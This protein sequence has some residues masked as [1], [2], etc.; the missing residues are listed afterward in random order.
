MVRLV[1]ATAPVDRALSARWAACAGDVILRYGPTVSHQ[2]NAFALQREP[3][4][5]F[6]R[7]LFDRLLPR[8]MQRRSSF[9][10]NLAP[11]ETTTDFNYRNLVLIVLDSLAQFTDEYVPRLVTKNVEFRGYFLLL[12]PAPAHTEPDIRRT[13]QE[14][15]NLR[16]HNVLIGLS[17]GSRIDLY[18]YRPYGADGCCECIRPRVVDRCVNG[19]LQQQWQQQQQGPRKGSTQP[20]YVRFGRNFYGCPLRISSFVRVPFMQFTDHSPS[21]VGGRPQLSGIEGNL[22]ELL[23]VK[24]NFTPIIV[25]PPDGQVWG[26]IYANGTADG[27]M[28][29]LLDGTAHLTLG[30][31]LPYPELLSRTTQSR[32][33][34]FS[35]IVLAVREGLAPQT[36]FGR[37]LQPF[38]WPIWLLVG[39]ELLLAAVWC[40]WG[41]LQRRHAGVRL[42]LDVWRALIGDSLPVLPRRSLTRFL[43]VLWILHSTLLREC[44]KGSLVGYLTAATPLDDISS[45]RVMLAGGYR[46]AMTEWLYHRIFEGPSSSSTPELPGDTLVLFEASEG[47]RL[48]E[49]ILASGERIAVAYTREEII[50]FNER[51]RSV[52][53]FRTADEKLLTF[54]FSAYFKRS[55]PLV[56]GFNWYIRRILATGFMSRWTAENLDTRFLV[57]TLAAASGQAEVLQLTHLSSSYLL[58]TVGLALACFT[59]AVELL[60][61]RIG[62]GLPMLRS[63]PEARQTR[64]ETRVAT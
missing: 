52:V 6:Q 64:S 58:L 14:L 59:F 57:P 4:A 56:D 50:K 44:Y 33:Y 28:K 15:W 10:V 38:R 34:Y 29:L 21:V 35:D 60:V 51:D 16:I 61:L 41:L 36:G 39:T 55:S 23:A 46:F 32:S 11:Y 9:T 27:A 22:L 54:H 62:A 3:G 49:R 53:N 48:L 12:L 8:L 17:A 1:F 30:G 2:V 43:L 19:R 45:I 31:Y 63:R 37:L 24:L 26:R 7:D 20:L 42:A 18:T 40:G 47:E 13:M 25:Q 5:R